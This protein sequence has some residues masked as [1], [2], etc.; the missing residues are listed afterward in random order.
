MKALRGG[1]YWLVLL[2]VAGVPA[3]THAQGPATEQTTPANGDSAPLFRIFLRDGQSLIS[4]GEYARLGDTVVFSMPTSAADVSAQLQLINVATDRIDWGRTNAYAETVRANRYL[5]TRAETDYAALTADV[6]LT[7]DRVSATESV[8]VRLD[9]VERARRTLA[10]W[11]AT[12]FNYKREDV[13]QMLGILDEVIATLR[14][15]AGSSSFDFSLVASAPSPEPAVPLLPAPTPQETIQ[16]TLIAATVTDISAERMS[17]LTV[18]LNSIDAAPESV[19]SEWL[20]KARSETLVQ[21]ET[22]TAID[23]RYRSLSSRLIGAA[24]ASAKLADVRGVERVLEQIDRDDA[25]LGGRRPDAI[26]ALIASVEAELDA[27]RRLRLARD[28]WALTAPALRAYRRAMVP[29]LDRFRRMA[30]SL[31]NIKALAGSA[32]SALGTILSVTERLQRS[33]AIIRP[34]SQ[35]TDVH[36]MFVSAVQLAANAA[37]IRREAAINNSMP[38][39]WDAS[40]AAAGALMLL[41]RGRADLAAALTPPQYIR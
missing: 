22:E 21:I 25:A 23:Q 37:I 41:T 6:A 29:A 12:H 14:A 33:M 1:G 16:S 40:S 13:Q 39:A 24:T 8:A 4:F 9:L 32:P 35:L 2:L 7:L 36:N 38:R 19:P 10:E 20:A 17:L 27:A 3:V 30:P 26:T 28:Q 15:A 11:P 31:E 5:A 34:P 18:A